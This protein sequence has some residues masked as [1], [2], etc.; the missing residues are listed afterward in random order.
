MKKLKM[1][2][3]IPGKL[4]QRGEFIDFPIKWKLGELRRL[5]VDIVVN[6]WNKPDVELQ[7]AIPHYYHLPIPDSTIK[8]S[9]LLLKFAREVAQLI[10]KGSAAIVHCHAGRNRSGMF[11]ALLCVELLGLSGIEA[12]DYIRRKRPNSLANENF[13]EFLC[14]QGERKLKTRKIIAIGGVPGTGKTQLIKEFMSQEKGWETC[15]P[16]ALLTAE[17]NKNLDLYV[18]GKYEEGETFAGTDKLS[19]AVQPKVQEWIKFCQ[20]NIV[21]EGDRLF[22]KSFLEFVFALPSIELFIIYLKTSPS[23]LS[24]RYQARGSNQSETFL[25][26]RETKYNNIFRE[27]KFKK[28]SREFVHEIPEDTKNVLC[29]INLFLDKGEI[30]GLPASEQVGIRKFFRK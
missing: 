2:E 10:R 26:G 15:C 17:Y 20:S 29:G 3:I 27:M 7:E 30:A 8:D 6:L 4:Y 22:N 5:N 25:K 23:V 19:M 16:A 28:I 18:L 24:Q 14:G 13:V 1:Y 9:S 11:N 12:I 21:F